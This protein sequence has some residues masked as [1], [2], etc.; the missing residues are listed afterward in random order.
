MVVR[1]L[2][3]RPAMRMFGWSLFVLIAVTLGCESDGG[4][5]VVEVPDR[6]S[7]GA[8][9]GTWE[10]DA[11]DVEFFSCDDV[12]FPGPL[13]WC[14]EIELLLP[15]PA[16]GCGHL[17]DGL[18]LCLELEESTMSSAAGILEVSEGVFPNSVG[19]V[20]E[21]VFWTDGEELVVRPYEMTRYIFGNVTSIV[22]CE[23]RGDWRGR[24]VAE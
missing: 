19:T 2:S 6:P 12:F 15:N 4:V 16:E 22:H 5:F 9:T 24:K 23:A 20:V 17:C 14:G 1:A 10:L 21:A 11:V 13:S 8:L 7:V 18:E 3:K